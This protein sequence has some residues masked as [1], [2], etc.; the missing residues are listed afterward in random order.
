MRT[1]NK[2]GIG[3]CSVPMWMAGSPAGHCDEPAYGERPPGKTHRRR[4]GYEWRDDGRYP[5]YVPGL[6]CPI[7]GGPKSRVFMDG[8]AWCAVWP[9]FENIQES[10]CAFA[11]TPERARQLLG[12]LSRK[13]AS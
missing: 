4:D 5:G 10:D 8:N 12:E 9:D 6:A 2:P 3:A 7:H 11:E 13:D 1:L